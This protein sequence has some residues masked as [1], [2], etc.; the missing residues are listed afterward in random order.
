VFNR[1]L[2]A[3]IRP[4]LRYE[5]NWVYGDN[6]QNWGLVET[7]S[8]MAGAPD[9]ISFYAT[10]HYWVG[11]YTNYR[12]FTIRVDGFVSVN[13]PGKGDEFTTKPF[14]FEGKELE[15]NFSTSVAGYVRVEIQDANGRPIFGYTLKDSPQIFGDE[16][17]RVVAWKDGK[18]V[19][20]LSGQPI[21]LRFVMRDADLYS[22]KF[23]G[24]KPSSQPK[25]HLNLKTVAPIPLPTTQPNTTLISCPECGWLFN[26]TNPKCDRCGAINGEARG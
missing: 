6:Y 8:D 16:L 24:A 2:E 19:S 26:P 7:K 20:K 1:W 12:R 13:A 10:E 22:I 3:F 9:E 21:R 25:A 17:D 18:D 14:T 23:Q 5:D 11:A 4:G 15:M